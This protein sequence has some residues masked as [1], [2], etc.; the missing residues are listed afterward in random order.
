MLNAPIVGFMPRLYRGGG[1][2]TPP[3]FSAYFASL[4]ADVPLAAGSRRRRIFDS[5]SRVR[6]KG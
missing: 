5:T 3:G 6:S 2:G 4:E 1:N